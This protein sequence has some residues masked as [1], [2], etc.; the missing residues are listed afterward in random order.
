MILTC[1]ISVQDFTQQPPA[2]ELTAM[3]LHGNEWKFRHIFRG[4][5]HHQNVQYH[6]SDL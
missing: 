3:D 1:Y 2:Q 6:N 4:M 5:Y